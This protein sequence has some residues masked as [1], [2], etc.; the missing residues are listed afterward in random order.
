MVS[1]LID[2][3]VPSF[4]LF[5]ELPKGCCILQSCSALGIVHCYS[6]HILSLVCATIVFGEDKSDLVKHCCSLRAS[7]GVGSAHDLL[8]LKSSMHC[9]CLASHTLNKHS[10]CHSTWKAVRIE[11]NVWY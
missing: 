8:Y 7:L 3:T 11:Q 4:L 1:L 10:N 9:S 6:F 2:P 5:L